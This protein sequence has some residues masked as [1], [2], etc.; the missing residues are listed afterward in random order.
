MTVVKTEAKS[1]NLTNLWNLIVGA[2]MFPSIM[3]P[4]EGRAPC[5]MFKNS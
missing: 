1:N 5:E 2:K 3:T 4:W